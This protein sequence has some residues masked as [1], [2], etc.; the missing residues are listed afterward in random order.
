MNEDRWRLARQARTLM[1]A[2]EAL[3]ALRPG[4]ADPVAAWRE[5]Y[6]RSSRV[7]AEIAEIDRGHHHEAL[8]WAGRE[9][10]KA[11]ALTQRK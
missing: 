10:R 11:E 6:Q 7:Y 4:E 5:Y 1:Q 3:T 9:R 8:Y 2:H